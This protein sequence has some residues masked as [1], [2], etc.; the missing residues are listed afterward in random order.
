MFISVRPNYFNRLS[1][2]FHMHEQTI[3]NSTR[4]RDDCKLVIH[5]AGVI[6]YV[7]VWSVW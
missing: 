2:L 1:L 6:V 3:V 5:V 4:L 7:C